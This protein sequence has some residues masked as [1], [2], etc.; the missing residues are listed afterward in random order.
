MVLKKGI[1]QSPT[2]TPTERF[3]RLRERRRDVLRSYTQDVD[4]SI[5]QRRA[6]AND[7]TKKNRKR[8]HTLLTRHKIESFAAQIVAA[9][10]SLKNFRVE[11]KAIDQATIIML[12]EPINQPGQIVARLRAQPKEHEIDG[13]LEVI[14]DE[15]QGI[16]R[17]QKMLSI[18]FKEQNGKS[19]SEALVDTV[20]TAA[21]EAGFDRVLIADIKNKNSYSDPSTD[22]IRTHI[23]LQNR[24]IPIT[25]KM[26]K[27]LDK[28][29][30]RR[31]QAMRDLYE[32]TRKR[33]GFTKETWR[34]Q[35]NSSGQPYLQH[36][37]FIEFP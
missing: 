14:I 31:R 18:D 24:G 28:D 6:E 23:N 20:K 15:F 29:L 26:S 3:N 32:E 5:D 22:L 17:H 30:D 33:S 16:G 11:A 4:K 36:Y 19:W 13:K 37:W 34:T 7:P 2:E 25:E 1:R 9:A 12:L 35:Y 10:K 27:I 8:T 21:Y